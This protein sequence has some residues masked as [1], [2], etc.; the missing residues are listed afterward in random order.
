MKLVPSFI[1]FIAY[2]VHVRSTP[3]RLT[4]EVIPIICDPVNGNPSQVRAIGFSSGTAR[5]IFS[6]SLL[7]RAYRANYSSE[8]LQ[9]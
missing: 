4:I 9:P 3:R 8:H 2:S 6:K 1:F 5:D 7:G